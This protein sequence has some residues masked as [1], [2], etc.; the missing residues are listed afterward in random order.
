MWS[1]SA[2]AAAGWCASWSIRRRAVGVEIS[3]RQLAAAVAHDGGSGARYLVGR[4]EDLPLA[5]ATMDA[6]VFMRTLHHVPTAD[7]TVAL[8]EAARVLRP[9]GVVYVVEPL[10]EGDYFELVS[11]VEDEVEVREAA[12][13]ALRDAA[14]VGLL[15][16]TTVEYEVAMT[17]SSIA[18]LRTR[19]VSVDP[20]RA[21]V[22]DALRSSWGTRWRGSVSRASPRAN[23]ASCSRCVPTCCGPS[24]R[25]A[26][27]RPASR[28]G[29]RRAPRDRR[30]RGPSARPGRWS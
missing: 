13:R 9:G 6:A 11:I 8:G 1:T 30:R 26:G 17:I 12:Q 14:D 10:A 22:F 4:G 23:A 3:E 19:V 16:Q 24:W 15:R 21:A 27:A 25:A 7:Q 29:A 20:E 5:D 28:R 2:A 18:A